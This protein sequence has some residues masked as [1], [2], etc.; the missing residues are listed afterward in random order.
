MKVAI[1][2]NNEQ[3]SHPVFCCGRNS[4]CLSSGGRGT[5]SPPPGVLQP[6]NRF[7]RVRSGWQSEEQSLPATDCH[8][9]NKSGSLPITKGYISIKRASTFEC[10]SSSIKDILCLAS[11]V[12][13]SSQ[14]PNI[15]A[16]GIL[17]TLRLTWSKTHLPRSTPSVWLPPTLPPQGVFLKYFFVNGG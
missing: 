3:P 4:L 6:D 15:P 16:D 5:T 7:Q 1:K 10:H 2:M 11:D 17:L 13:L 9:L 12:C 8:I 14:A